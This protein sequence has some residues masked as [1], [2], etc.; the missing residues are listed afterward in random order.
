[1]YVGPIDHTFFN[2]DIWIFLRELVLILDSFTW[3]WSG[4]GLKFCTSHCSF[5][6]G[7]FYK[8][9]RKYEFVSINEELNKVNWGSFVRLKN[10]ICYG[11]FVAIPNEIVDANMLHIKII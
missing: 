5:S 6:S 4:L 3:P 7:K 10:Y 11:V 1:M 2:L 9:V 8:Y